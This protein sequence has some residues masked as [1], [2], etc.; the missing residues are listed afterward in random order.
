MTIRPNILFIMTD[1]QHSH[2]MSCAGNPHVQTPNMDRMAEAGIRFEHAYC[3]NPVC[4]P[5][6]FS[7]FTGLMPSAIG[8]RDNAHRHLDK[9]ERLLKDGIGWKLKAAGYDAVYGGKEHFPNYRATDLGFD[10]IEENE[11][12]RLA[13]TCA[14]WLKAPHEKPFFMVASF[15]NPHDI[16]LM[17]IS[18]SRA[19]EQ[20]RRLCEILPL[21]I[22]TVRQA[23][24][25]PE[26]VGEKEFFER[27]APPLPDNFDIQEDEPEMVS[28]LIDERPFRRMEREQWTEERWREHRWAYK[29]LTEKVDAE[30]GRVLEAL[31]QSGL[32][33][34]TL[35]IFTSD[36]GDHDGAH[37]MEHKT[38]YYVEA[39]RIPFLVCG[40]GV[41]RQG[42]VDREFLISN[43]LDLAPTVYDYAG[44]EM[45][46]YCRGRSIRPIV[47][48]RMEREDRT[49][50][51]M[52]SQ[53]GYAAVNRTHLYALYDEGRNREQLYDLVSDPGQTRNA[54]NDA[55]C[56]GT[57]TAMRKAL[58]HDREVFQ[59]MRSA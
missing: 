14:Q 10:Y 48:G 23:L 37:R 5:S 27:Y 3:T 28:R 19:T 26:G 31:E 49:H 21:E 6:R 24:E 2:M 12:D 44:I 20:E 43:G 59:E 17:G 38:A 54:L 7:L 56:A 25:R 15:I 36:H 41:S 29:R 34:R 53:V 4:V 40:A 11:R 8:L 47:E 35:V 16:C 52:E 33:D 39:C 9:P 55:A 45:P 13:E 50:L 57:L 30:I 42:V 18:E 22:E 1:Q 58:Q 46:A 51:P 32:A